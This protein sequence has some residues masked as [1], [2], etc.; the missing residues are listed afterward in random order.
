MRLCS[1]KGAYET[2]TTMTHEHSSGAACLCRQ[3]QMLSPAMR[4]LC[5]HVYRSYADTPSAM[6]AACSERQRKIT[7]I[8][9]S[10]SP[11]L[12]RSSLSIHSWQP[13]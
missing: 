6:E 8:I 13:A 1:C 9:T 3:L 12:P 7:S 4:F 10:A 5:S 2:S 11:D